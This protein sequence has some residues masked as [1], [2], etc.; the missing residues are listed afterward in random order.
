MHRG[1]TKRWR[2]RW[3]KG[4]HRD[5]LLWVM[6]DYFIDHANYEATERFFP[7]YGL[8]KLDRGQLPFGIPSLA[9]YLKTTEK[10]IRS[11]LE[12]LKKTDFLAIQTTNRFSIATI[13]NYDKYNPRVDIKGQTDGQSE[14]K[15]R[16]NR[17]QHLNKDNKVNKDK[18]DFSPY[19]FKF[20]NDP[21]MESAW[22][23]FSNPGHTNEDLKRHC[24]SYNKNYE[25]IRNYLSEIKS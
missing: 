2:K 3:D 20:P 12:I 15:Q 8:L 5:H 11:R 1:Y 24:D 25:E 17:G 9:K 7:N 23:I 6:M 14:G 13:L 22:N 4:F 21:F 19:N 18:G 16:A 10:R